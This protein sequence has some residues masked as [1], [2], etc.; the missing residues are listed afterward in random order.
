MIS[1]DIHLV[2]ELANLKIDLT[3]LKHWCLFNVID[4][5]FKLDTYIQ[6]P[7]FTLLLLFQTWLQTQSCSKLLSILSILAQLIELLRNRIL[8]FFV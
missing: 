7:S 8:K 3:L 1:W 2:H 6:V 4:F 5:F